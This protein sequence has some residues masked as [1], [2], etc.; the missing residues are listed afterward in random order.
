MDPS[1]GVDDQRPRAAEVIVLEIFRGKKNCSDDTVFV[2]CHASNP[3]SHV[4]AL[5]VDAGQKLAL[6]RVVSARRLKGFIQ[7]YSMDLMS[8]KIERRTPLKLIIV[9]YLKSW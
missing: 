1:V 9:G 2:D 4:Q 6:L 7:L 3:V 8:T 5:A